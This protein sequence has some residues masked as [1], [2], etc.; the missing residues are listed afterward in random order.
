MKEKKPNTIS[1]SNNKN[2]QIT[3]SVTIKEMVEKERPREKLLA[4]GPKELSKTELLAIILNTGTTE[5]NVIQ[6]A[7][8]FLKKHNH[9]LYDMYMKNIATM[10][11]PIPGIGPAKRAKVL[12]ALELGVRLI[13]DREKYLGK[14]R[15]LNKS[16]LI[17]N[18]MF[19]KLF[20]LMH[21][22]VWALY[23]NVQFDLIECVKISSGGITESVAD[24]KI[25][26]KNALLYSA[27]SIVLVHNHPAGSLQPSRSDDELTER[28]K[29]ACRV[30]GMNLADHIIFTDNGFFSYAD[31]SRL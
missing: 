17:Y 5:L 28:L 24:V 25:I 6:L 3:K 2:E 30:V 21:E 13:Q 10:T 15:L 4:K 14:T 19:D 9:N 18:Y 11:N 31:S 8:S 22:E 26:L 23:F 16:K 29:S 1:Y 7:E 12:A 27:I 20:G